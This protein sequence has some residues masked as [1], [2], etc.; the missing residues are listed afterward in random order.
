MSAVAVI[1]IKRF[2]HR[3]QEEIR[4]FNPV[5]RHRYHH[6]LFDW[7]DDNVRGIWFIKVIIT[8]PQVWG[9]RQILDNELEE[10]HFVFQDRAEAMMFK[11]TWG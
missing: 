4:F 9:E 8:D 2:D 10:V 7:M 6:A 3:L 1:P 11:L 5:D